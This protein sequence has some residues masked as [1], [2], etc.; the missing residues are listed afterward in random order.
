M[1][2]S[3]WSSDVC[4]SDL[5]LPAEDDQ[6][7]QSPATACPRWLR[8]YRYLRRV[9]LLHQRERDG[10]ALEGRR[11]QCGGVRLQPRDR[12]GLPR[13]LEN[14]AGVQPEGAA[15]EQTLDQ[16]LRDGEGDRKGVVEGKG[17]AVRGEK[18]G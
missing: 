16:L 18:G 9:V 8:R 1:R 11:Q 15:Q 10:R 2:I 17:G 12:H 13:V 3:D 5:A 4:S 6:H 14:H 7:R